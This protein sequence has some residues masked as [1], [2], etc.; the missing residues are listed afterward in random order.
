MIKTP[1]L[2]EFARS[3]FAIYFSSIFG[4]FTCITSSAEMNDYRI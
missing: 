2:E 3:H 1:A 4:E